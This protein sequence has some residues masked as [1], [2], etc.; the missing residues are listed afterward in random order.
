M[1]HDV[2]GLASVSDISGLAQG[3]DK[4][5]VIVDVIIIIGYK[6]RCK[7]FHGTISVLVRADRCK[8]YSQ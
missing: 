4:L 3:K 6:S 1:V 8:Q 2:L 5:G 7:R